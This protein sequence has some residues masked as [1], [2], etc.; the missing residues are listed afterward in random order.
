[1]EIIMSNIRRTRIILH[2]QPNHF[3][4]PSPLAKEFPAYNRQGTMQNISMQKAGCTS[5]KGI[6]RF[7]F[8][9]FWGNVLPSVFNGSVGATFE[10]ATTA[11][12][13]G[14]SQSGGGDTLKLSDRIEHCLTT[15]LSTIEVASLMPSGSTRIQEIFPRTAA[16]RVW[17]L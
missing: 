13:E 4:M 16:H 3:M 11:L 2:P 12:R 7:V 5:H 6:F 15:S 14:P 17:S 10:Q 1:M 9:R 8:L